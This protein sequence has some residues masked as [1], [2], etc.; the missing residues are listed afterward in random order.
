MKEI[1]YKDDFISIVKDI[2]NADGGLIYGNWRPIVADGDVRYWLYDS[3]G[4]SIISHDG[5]RGKYGYKAIYEPCEGVI[6]AEFTDGEWYL[7]NLFGSLLKPYP[8]HS[9]SQFQNG[10]GRV[11]ME[12]LN[13]TCLIDHAGNL[14]LQNKR[15]Q[16]VKIPDNYRGGVWIDDNHIALYHHYDRR[17]YLYNGSFEPITLKHWNGETHLNF[18]GVTDAPL[19]WCVYFSDCA[20]HPNERVREPLCVFNLTT[21]SVLYPSNPSAPDVPKEKPLSFVSVGTEC[22]RFSCKI[23]EEKLEWDSD[24]REYYNVS[25]HYPIEYLCFKNGTCFADRC[26]ALIIEELECI[27]INGE[28]CIVNNQKHLTDSGCLSFSGETIVPRMFSKVKLIEDYFE[29]TLD[30][31]QFK[32]N[33]EGHLLYNNIA[34]PSGIHSFVEIREGV[35]LVKQFLGGWRKEFMCGIYSTTLND[36]I[37]PI[38]YKSIEICNQELF[39][40]CKDDQYGVIDSCFDD[41]IPCQYSSLTYLADDKF[42]CATKDGHGI[43]NT[44]KE[45]LVQPKY[46][47]ISLTNERKIAFYSKYGDNGWY[48][49]NRN[50]VTDLELNTIIMQDDEISFKMKGFWDIAGGF[51]DNFSRFI[52]K[53]GKWGL[54]NK[55]S[56]IVTSNL[57]EKI[58]AIGIPDVFIGY[59]NGETYLLNPGR[60]VEK[61][62][63]CDD[64]WKNEYSSNSDYLYLSKDKKLGLVD[65]KGNV[66]LECK[67]SDISI[68]SSH[69]ALVI[70]NCRGKADLDGNI[71]I[72]C[73]Y[74]S[75]EELPNGYYIVSNEYSHLISPFGVVLTSSHERYDCIL[76][77][78]ADCLK[79]VVINESG[80]RHYGLISLKGQLIRKADLSHIG[81]FVDGEAVAN[82]GGKSKMR[83][84][85]AS[86]CDRLCVEGGKKG[87]IDIDGFFVIEPKY[88]Y[89]GKESDGYRVI[90]N[91]ISGVDKYGIVKKDGTEL[92]PCKYSYL[93]N[94]SDGLIV[95]AVSGEWS[96]DG[97]EKE[98]LRSLR[99]SSLNYLVGAKWGL[100]DLRENILIE[101]FADFMQ[102]VSEKKLTYRFGE[103][104]GII[105]T[106]ILSMQMTKYDYLSSFYEGRCIAGEFVEN[107]Y[108]PMMRFGYIKDDYTELVPC[109]YEKAYQFSEGKA[110]LIDDNTQITI[111]INGN[112]LESYTEDNDYYEP[113]DT[114]WERETWYALTDG[115][116]G[117][118]PGSGVDYDALG[119]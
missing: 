3:E 108:G 92:I 24:E 61:K 25:N 106:D 30:D 93:R 41:V 47:S 23:D 49:G 89:I 59:V 67:Y 112:V 102:F 15:N 4:K 19:D 8:F 77:T 65:F 64:C 82:F 86:R 13:N 63:D 75:Y 17:F 96:E 32:F 87:V 101:P 11:G 118:Y 57:Y 20:C 62:I 116:Y 27:L 95:F 68:E 48:Y 117:D 105:E 46:E 31:Q 70:G 107:K 85:M 66:I 37:L 83:Y 79:T 28:E 36:F 50:F 54:V 60:H 114:D 2:Y 18:G 45:I 113:D 115:L 53:N 84:D 103:K 21:N 73:I 69:I 97:F 10:F 1:V 7:F 110:T 16:L 76:Q 80:E 119:F 109:S 72:P 40:V 44:N 58:D 55:D 52:Y 39:I 100:M 22:I 90:V 6:R 99:D 14:Y 12:Y 38:E 5:N 43:I 56:K 29:A 34:L 9:T 94:V 51:F 88:D 111:D 35:L 98:K 74:E 81:N 104:Y 71:I 33:F 26:T 91:K 78:D 42:V